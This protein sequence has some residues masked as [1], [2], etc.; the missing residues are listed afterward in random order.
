MVKSGVGFWW[1]AVLVGGEEGPMS[2][3]LGYCQDHNAGLTAETP[4]KL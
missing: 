1:W 2:V 4:L 3:D